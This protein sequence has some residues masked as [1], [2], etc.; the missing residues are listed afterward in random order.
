M[1]RR[2]SL[3]PF[4]VAHVFYLCSL[5]KD[6]GFACHPNGT[7]HL[8]NLSNTSLDHH[9]LSETRYRFDHVTDRCVP[10]KYHGCGGNWNNFPTDT[11]CSLRCSKIAVRISGTTRSVLTISEPY[12]ATHHSYVDALFSLKLG[13]AYFTGVI[14]FLLGALIYLM[15]LPYVRKSGYFQVRG[16]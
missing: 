6:C 14:E 12:H 5:P 7:W 11:S 1:S 13:L 9:W 15:C 10:F 3:F 4:F 8:P 2:I 16:S